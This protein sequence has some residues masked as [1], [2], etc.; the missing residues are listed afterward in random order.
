MHGL[1]RVDPTIW[2]RRPLS[3]EMLAYAADDVQGLLALAGK[4]RAELGRAGARAVA[5]LSDMNA[6]W[7]F[8]ADDRACAGGTYACARPSL[9]SF[10]SS[11][12][13][14]V[15]YKRGVDRAAAA[16]IRWQLDIPV[17]LD[18]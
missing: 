2:E 18:K 4:L 11:R 13:E 6:Q 17:H 8:D 10:L 16:G 5:R 7:H 9:P 1:F 15:G 12:V 3:A 14:E